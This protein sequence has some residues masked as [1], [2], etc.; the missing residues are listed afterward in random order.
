MPWWGKS[1]ESKPEQAQ[2]QDASSQNSS[3]DPHK[4]PSRE[5]LPKGMQKI[6][7]KADEDSGFFD[8]LRE[9]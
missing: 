5:R 8:E 1:K 6:V 7:D 2:E 4:L 9:G 3:F